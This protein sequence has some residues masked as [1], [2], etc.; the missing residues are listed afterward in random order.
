MAKRLRQVR[1]LASKI[2]RKFG[3]GNQLQPEP[4]I[5]FE[6]PIENDANDN[7]QQPHIEEVPNLQP[8]NQEQTRGHFQIINGFD[9]EEG[10]EVYYELE[11][12]QDEEPLE[13]PEHEAIT[14]ELTSEDSDKESDEIIEIR[15][16][17]NNNGWGETPKLVE[18]D[19]WGSTPAKTDMEDPRVEGNTPESGSWYPWGRDSIPKDTNCITNTN[20]IQQPTTVFK[21]ITFINYR[22]QPLP[23]GCN[24]RKLQEATIDHMSRNYCTRS[25]NYHCCKCSRPLAKDEVYEGINIYYQLCRSCD[26][27]ERY[28]V[29][30]ESWYHQPCQVCGEPLEQKE[31]I[32]WN[33]YCCST[34]C[35]YAYLAISSSKMFEHIP[36]RVYH[37]LNTGRGQ[38]HDIDEREVLEKAQN[39]FIKLYGEPEPERY[40]FRMANNQE[41]W[42]EARTRVYQEA[43]N[44]LIESSLTYMNIHYNNNAEYIQAMNESFERNRLAAIAKL[45]VTVDLTEDDRLPLVKFNLC[46]NC[47]FP[48]SNDDLRQTNDYKFLCIKTDM[49]LEP[50]WTDPITEEITH[51]VQEANEVC[52]EDFGKEILRQEE[53]Q[54]KYCKC[55]SKT[56]MSERQKARYHRRICR[57]GRK[58]FSSIEN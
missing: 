6:R 23:C 13:Y 28:N 26:R 27:S 4:T 18:N 47:Y 12:V 29:A 22:R 1:K 50:C 11:Q 7:N 32:S 36:T 48:F 45:K 42:N 24:K 37:Y 57:D 19:N 30:D 41:T 16:P 2:F 34:T 58:K 9:N 53:N 46:H 20:E 25:K 43:M 51:I 40:N 10:P 44:Y 33:N 54:N 52:G 14:P 15:E 3:K 55:Y 21:P 17:N 38:Y 31:N 49:N 8:I 39:F 56:F 35:K 5:I